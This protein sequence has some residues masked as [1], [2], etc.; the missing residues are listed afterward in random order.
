MDNFKSVK[1]TNP[2]LTKYIDSYYFHRNENC[3]KSN[4][5]TFF[6]NV[7]NALTIY[8]N[9][10]V[11]ILNQ[12]PLRIKVVNSKT[13][14]YTFLYGGIQKKFVISEMESPFNKIGIIFKPLGINHFLT[15]PNLGLKLRKDYNFPY[16]KEL[17]RNELSNIFSETC[18]ENKIE[19]LDQF[20][21]KSLNPDFNEPEVEKVITLIEN[22]DKSL[23][24]S[25]I[26]DQ[27]SMN[28]KA[29]CRKFK[30]N[31]NCTPKFYSKV[32]HFRK[33]LNEYQNNNKNVKL[34]H[35]AFNNSY[36]DQS[37]FIKNFKILTGDKP[38]KILKNIEDFGH[39]IFWIK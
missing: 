9:A 36:Y 13:E 38:L 28:S 21:I 23:K 24:I 2:I 16:F 10:T 14:N 5:I 32:F 11:N 35:L 31:L 20:F 30:N 7:N 1:N 19:I 27:L 12:D 22:S 33:A 17:F 4:C 34:T 39:N 25:D 6:P 29:I 3:K 26:S 15:I 8:Q 37:D 18:L